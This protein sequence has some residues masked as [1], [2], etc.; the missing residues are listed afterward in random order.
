[1][2]RDDDLQDLCS[3]ANLQLRTMPLM[4]RFVLETSDPMPFALSLYAC[5]A[6]HCVRTRFSFERRQKRISS[7]N[8]NVYL[9]L[10]REMCKLR[11]ATLLA[12]F[13]GALMISS[14]M[15]L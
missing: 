14:V 11:N 13:N 5:P 1:M 9:D 7:D 15:K 8:N 10:V 4:V 12:C 3:G 6:Q 2:E